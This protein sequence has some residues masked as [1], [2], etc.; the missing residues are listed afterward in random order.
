MS[1]DITPLDDSGVNQPLVSWWRLPDRHQ[2]RLLD[3]EVKLGTTSTHN[4][5]PTESHLRWCK[6]QMEDR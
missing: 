3:L 2:G 1:W 6:T 4:L 5:G